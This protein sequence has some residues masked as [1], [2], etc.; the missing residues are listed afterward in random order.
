[1]R[2]AN[3]GAPTVP[4]TRRLLA[5]WLREPLLHF[6]VAGAAVFV[7]FHALN[8]AVARSEPANRIRLTD[9][10]LRQM[11]AAW[12]GQG[13][14]S[15]SPQQ[16][17]SLVEA[18]VREEILF[19]EAL[20][21]GLDKNDTIVRRR[22]AQKM[23]F[24]TDD[25]SAVPEPSAAE[26]A[27]WFT[28]NAERFAVPAR[29]SFRHLYFSPDRRGARAMHDATAVLA[30][31]RRESPASPGTAG[32]EDPFMFQDRYVDRTV[33]Q[34]AGIFGSAFARSLEGLPPGSW[35]GPIASG[36]GRHLVF[37]EGVTPKRVPALEEVGA[38]VRREW[39]AER[40]AEV[41]RDVYGA[42]RARYEVIVPD[43]P[44]ARADNVANGQ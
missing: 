18:R 7:A 27:A 3:D 22:L 10:D 20:A 37:I 5:R 30:A 36:Y 40:R 35:Q 11:S 42:I 21:L 25:V 33:D 19:R 43:I 32:A 34:V 16:M 17:E 23:E 29:V 12:R 13:R 31:M 15:P 24:L 41:K 4:P 2:H 9:D 26:L 8:P 6:L 28:R 44:A 1:M 14:P 38:D 39:I